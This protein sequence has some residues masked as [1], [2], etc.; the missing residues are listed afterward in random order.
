MG[1]VCNCVCVRG[2]LIFAIVILHQTTDPYREQCQRA[3]DQ[4][5]LKGLRSVHALVPD[6]YAQYTHQFLTRMLSA[7][8]SSWHICSVH[9][10]VPDANAQSTHQFL[11]RMLSAR[12]CWNGKNWCACW[13]CT[14]D[15]KH[16]FKMSI[17][18]WRVRSVHSSVPDPYAQRAHKGWSMHIRKSKYLKCLKHQKIKKIA[19][20]TRK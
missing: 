5:V 20:D 11:T 13:A 2:S 4:H 18:S 7:C 12:A 8:I 16:M 14:E 6:T 17:I 19:I 10:P 9:T 15:I 3:Y 1:W